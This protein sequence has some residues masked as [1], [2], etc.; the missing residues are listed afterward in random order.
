[1]LSTK[2]TPLGTS[3][4]GPTV[5]TFGKGSPFETTPQQQR[6]GFELGSKELEAVVNDSQGRFFN[7]LSAPLSASKKK[8]RD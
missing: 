7:A 5:P 2:T 6:R 3:L 1:M 8:K 4:K